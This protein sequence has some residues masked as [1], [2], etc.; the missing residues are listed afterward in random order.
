MTFDKKF[1]VDAVNQRLNEIPVPGTSS[2]IVKAG[3]IQRVIAHEGEVTIVIQ[4]P[5]GLTTQEGSISE[6]IEEELRTIKGVEK[7]TL[8]HRTESPA[9][10]PEPAS[11]APGPG[12]SAVGAQDIPGVSHVIAVAS[13]KGGVGKSTV[14]VN[15]AL[16]LA[17]RGLR[18]GLLDADVYGPSTPKMLGTEDARP[19]ATQQETIV[20][21]E[22]HGLKTMSIG[23]LLEDDSPVIWRGPMVTGLL[24][25][26]LFQVEWGELDYLVL[27]LPP[28]T[29]DAQLTLV[30]SIALAGGVIVT[31]PQDVA[32]LDVQ[33]GIQMFQRTN[34]PI[35]GV[36]ENMSGFECSSC[37][38]VTE[39]FRGG[40]GEDAAKRY[41]VPFLGKIPLE[42]QT[43]LSCDGGK[44]VMLSDPTGSLGSV[45]TSACEQ[46]VSLVAAD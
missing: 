10:A 31:T 29:G 27:D 42:P 32:L 39:I 9:A 12:P 1:I 6:R 24:R 17:A 19:Q 28:G 37:G 2:S 5:A 30:Q 4:F 46:I 3:V 14:A 45:M 36:L 16:A 18:T 20:P 25:Q 13:G 21:I 23:Y 26:F 38:H 33:R 35:L 15:L 40:G 34:V 7:V 41:S 8:L 22:V 11:G 43:A 44:P